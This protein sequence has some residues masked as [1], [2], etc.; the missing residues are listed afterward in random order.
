MSAVN[1]ENLSPVIMAFVIIRD[2]TLEKGLM[3]A[4]NVGNFL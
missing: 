2:F 3:N 4:V 1:V